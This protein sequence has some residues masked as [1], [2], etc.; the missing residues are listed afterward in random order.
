MPLETF[1]FDAAHYLTDPEAQAELLTDAIESGDANYIAVALGTVARARGM[2]QV[3]KEAGVTR[4]ALYKSL[5]PDGDPR[6]ST[7]LGVLKALGV[8]LTVSPAA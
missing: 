6:L 8:K 1:P 7:L 3:A 4:E 2:T 5:G